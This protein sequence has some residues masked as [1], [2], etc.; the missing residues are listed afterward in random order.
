MLIFTLNLY[1]T[2]SGSFLDAMSPLVDLYKSD[3]PISTNTILNELMIFGV[4]N[5][6]ILSHLLTIWS[7]Y[8]T[9]CF[10]SV[11]LLSRSQLRNWDIWRQLLYEKLIMS[12]RQ[13]CSSDLPVCTTHRGTPS[14]ISSVRRRRW[15]GSTQ[16]RRWNRRKRTKCWISPF[17]EFANWD[18]FLYLYPWLH[19]ASI[20]RCS[21]W[22]VFAGEK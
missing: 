2:L 10:L 7:C 8:I 11:R 21:T 13:A 12:P 3:N 14:V 18:Y 6:S 19:W 1:I 17:S 4:T 16:R 9:L 22:W 20:H 15:R 5:R